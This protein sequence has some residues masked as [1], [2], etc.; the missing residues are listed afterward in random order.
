MDRRMERVRT[1]HRW[2]GMTLRPKGPAVQR[3]PRPVGPRSADPFSV[4]YGVTPA[5]VLQR[6]PFP[7]VHLPQRVC[8]GVTSETTGARSSSD[9]QALSL[10]FSMGRPGSR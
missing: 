7:A 10:R 9:S 3:H 6:L 8:Q 5:V 1:L 4:A 2:A